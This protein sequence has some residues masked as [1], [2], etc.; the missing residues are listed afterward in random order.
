MKFYLI[1]YSQNLQGLLKIPSE[2]DAT[3]KELAGETEEA[4]EKLACNIVFSRFVDDVHS[5]PIFD[6]CNQSFQSS[7]HKPAE[8]K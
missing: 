5:S 2:D 6:S 7:Q 4:N 1:A 3:K 8:V